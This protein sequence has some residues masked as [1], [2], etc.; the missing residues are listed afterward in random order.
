MTIVHIKVVIPWEDELADYLRRDTG[1]MVFD[2]GSF[3][4]MQMF[5]IAVYFI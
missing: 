2:G 4:Q 3:C 5:E 1:S